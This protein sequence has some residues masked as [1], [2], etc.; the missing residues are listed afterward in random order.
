MVLRFFIIKSINS[1]YI[2]LKI[3]AEI[4]SIKKARIKRALLE[5]QELDPPLHEVF[6]QLQTSR[7]A[8]FRVEL[9]RKQ[10]FFM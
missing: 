5:E 2:F 9:G 1:I 8:L 3:K 4:K 6:Q 7:M 10:V